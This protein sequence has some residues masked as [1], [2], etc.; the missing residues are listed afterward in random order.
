MVCDTLVYHPSLNK[1]VNYLETTNGREKVLRLLQYLS[2]FLAVQRSSTQFKALQMQFTVVRKFLRFL[3]PISSFQAACKNY[4]NK[5]NKKDLVMYWSNIIKN[6]ANGLY[7]TFDQINLLRMLNVVP[8]TYFTANLVPRWS[9]WFWL[10]GILSSLVINFKSI[11]QNQM[12][13]VAIL[14][15]RRSSADNE[16]DKEEDK[17]YLEQAYR[18]RYLAVRKLIWDLLDAFIVLNNLNFLNNKD[19]YIAL[20]G[21]ATSLFGIQ[22][23]WKAVS[24]K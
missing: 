16:E 18:Q 1:L 12:K 21:V 15:E 14:K 5:L 3:K 7:L 20:S 6:L 23:L 19:G 2:R 24:T 13:I 17:K 4:D 10:Y 9:N 11:Q 8:K 22:D